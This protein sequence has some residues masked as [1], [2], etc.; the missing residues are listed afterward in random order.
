MHCLHLDIDPL[1]SFIDNFRAKPPSNPE[2]ASHTFQQYMDHIQDTL[3]TY[4]DGNLLTEAQ[5]EEKMEWVERYLC[6]ELYT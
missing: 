3:S 5:I 1:S 2:I 6:T 4:F